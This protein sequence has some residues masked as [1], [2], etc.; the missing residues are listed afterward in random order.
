[1]IASFAR[2]GLAHITAIGLTFVIPLVLSAL[3]R[4]DHGGSMNRIV[5]F[6]FAAILVIN[7]IIG[8]TL[9]SREG[10][11]TIASLVPMHLCDWAAITAV[12]TLI[13]PNQWTYELCYFWA[14]GG[15]FQALLTPDLREGFPH[16]QFFSF[17]T[18][19]GVVLAA[20]IYTTLAMKLRPVPNSIVRVLA[21][22]AVYLVVAAGVNLL[23]GTNFGYLRAKPEQPSL[24]DYLAPWPF[25]IIELGLLAILLCLACYLPFFV[26]DRLRLR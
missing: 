17:F 2:F 7:K 15:T 21:W 8:V 6:V 25:Y 3:A 9:L 13:Y 19:H 11:F 23:L 20:V 4:F 12:I 5:G 16:P 18:Q 14:L 24:M 22:T 1:M 26:I 10:E